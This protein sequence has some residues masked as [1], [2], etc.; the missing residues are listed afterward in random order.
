MR[1]FGFA[2]ALLLVAGA[3][4]AQRVSKVSGI[5][6]LKACTSPALKETCDAYVDGFGDA[7]SEGGKEHALAC[8]PIAS[9]GT[10]LRDVLV[11]YLKAHPEDQHLK[12]GTI[13]SHAFSKAYPCHR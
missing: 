5:T 2:L 10:E 12:A 6:L 13:A 4:Q 11:A 8:L 1:S 9:T 3:A 7:I